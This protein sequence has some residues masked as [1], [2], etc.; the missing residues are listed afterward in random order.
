MQSNSSSE[1]ASKPPA[2][3]FSGSRTETCCSEHDNLNPGQDKA[4]MYRR[5]NR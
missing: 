5:G 3:G 2:Q 1:H 4:A